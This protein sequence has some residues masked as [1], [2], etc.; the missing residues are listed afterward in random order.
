MCGTNLKTLWC[1]NLTI[2]VE[3]LFVSL[4]RGAEAHAV[5]P[6]HARHVGAD[7]R[8]WRRRRRVQRE[9]PPQTP[10]SGETCVSVGLNWGSGQVRVGVTCVTLLFHSDVWLRSNP[11]TW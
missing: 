10:P 6:H 7:L 9:I 3:L 4:L 5:R 11:S 8:R 1:H 2:H